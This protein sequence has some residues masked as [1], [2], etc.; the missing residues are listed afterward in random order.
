MS[1]FYARLGVT[2]PFD[3]SHTYTTSWL[4]PPLLLALIRSLFSLYAFCTIFTIFGYYDSHGEAIDNRQWFSYFTNLTYV[5]LAFYFLF[6]AIHTWSYWRTGKALLQSWPRPLQALHAVFYTT[7]VTYPFLVTIVY[8]G[9]LYKAPWFPVVE[10]AWSNVSK[11]A[12]N[13]AWALFEVLLT[14][15][16]PRPPLHMLFIIIL[17]ALYLGLAYLT[18][19]TEGFYVYSFL[20]PSTGVNHVVAYCIGIPVAACV[21]FGIVW[22]ILWLRNKATKNMTKYTHELSEKPDGSVGET[23]G[24]VVEMREEMK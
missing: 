9:V 14:C 17:L 15:T 24:E 6:S 11:H 18:K 20:D 1:K 13:S 23:Y 5:G 10:D 12:I 7:I 8:W 3:P 21:I 16:S 19:A 2:T 4:L 22:V